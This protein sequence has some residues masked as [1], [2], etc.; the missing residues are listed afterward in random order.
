MPSELLFDA[1]SHTYTLCGKR[2]PSVTQVL[3]AVGICDYSHIPYET[4]EAAKKRGSE[5]HVLTQ[6][7]DESDLD[8]ATINPELMGYLTA[9]RRFR[10]ETELGR[11]SLVKI[12]HRG[13]HR[14]GFA[15]TLDRE[16][17]GRILVDIKTGEF[18]YWV[19]L[20]LAAYAAIL[21]EAE[22]SKELLPFR[23]VG[24]ELHADG[25]FNVREC[26]VKE[27]RY[28]FDSFV[29]AHRVVM[30]KERQKS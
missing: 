28:D 29:A 21:S 12:E 4:R 8:E 16:F 15:G 26:P 3:E 13:Y 22:G 27:L 1:A 6:F 7:D 17:E 5:V 20:Q 23:R 30:E 19:R 24:V 9:W 10:T 11:K 25:T 18:P 2:L 14:Y